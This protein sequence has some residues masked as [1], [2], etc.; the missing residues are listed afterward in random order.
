MLHLLQVMIIT[1]DRVRNVTFGTSHD[2]N[3]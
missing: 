2:Y 1:S 3:Q